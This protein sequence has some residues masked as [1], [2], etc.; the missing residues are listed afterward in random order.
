MSHFA[1]IGLG[2]FAAMSIATAAHTATV[3]PSDYSD[4][5]T[6]GKRTAT[7][8]GTSLVGLSNVSAAVSGNGDVDAF[9][10]GSAASGNDILLVGRVTKTG[11]DQYYGM[12]G[13]GTLDIN[14]LNYG[15]SSRQGTTNFSAKFELAVG[16]AT[17][18][19]QTIM[20]SGTAPIIEMNNLFSSV[21][22]S[23]SET[24][25]FKVTSLSGKSDYDIELS[26]SPSVVPLPAGGLLLL[27]GLAG[28]G[29][30]RRKTRS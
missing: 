29:V 23:T 20:L 12:T 4:I 22:L 9:D 16:T 14:I 26:F 8:D 6:E 24:T 11:D 3:T 30:A 28:L 10:V 5:F 13:A 7:M 25:F 17:N 1:K 21:A 18:V 27:T 19:V 2:L 15:S